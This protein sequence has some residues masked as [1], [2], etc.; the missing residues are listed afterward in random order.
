MFKKELF[1]FLLL[2]ILPG[3]GSMLN[4]QPR[5]A[6][7]ISVIFDTDANNELDDQHALAYLLFNSDVFDIKGI[8]VNATRNGG[9]INEQLKE[10][11]RV[12]RLCNSFGKVPLLPGANKGYWAIEKQLHKKDFDG[13]KAVNFIIEQAQKKTGDKLVVLAVGKLTNLALALKVQPDIASKIRVVWLGSNYPKP[14]EYNLDDDFMALNYVLSQPVEF[15]M[16]VVRYNAPSGT[17]A[18]KFARADIRKI[19]PGMGPRLKEPV[20]GRHGNKFNCF[21]DYSVN[22][23]N[24]IKVYGA[25]SSRALYDMAAVAIVKNPSWAT[26]KEIPAPF[27]D[28]KNKRWVERPNN[29]RKIKYW[30]NFSVAAI[31]EDFYKSMKDYKTPGRNR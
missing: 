8:T 28:G 12:M 25:D 17:G 30:E 2:F 3:A 26:A 6:G 1:C 18:V 13:S 4:A 15:E 10:A 29:K 19:M 24:H 27:Y 11:E 22:L 9:D 31:S 23:F 14:G 16:A 21:G 5:D 20:E 7:K